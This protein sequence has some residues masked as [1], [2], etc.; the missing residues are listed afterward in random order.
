M[1]DVFNYYVKFRIILIFFSNY[2]EM[3][4]N[5]FVIFCDSA[6]FLLSNL[7]P[8]KKGQYPYEIKSTFIS[9][10]TW[11]YITPYIWK[12]YLILE[13][14]ISVRHI[15]VYDQLLKVFEVEV[16]DFADFL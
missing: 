14:F 6:D 1:F 9:N 16:S 4:T 12:I 13:I 10:H 7:S 11:K 15:Y 8:F 5:F 2:D 3:I